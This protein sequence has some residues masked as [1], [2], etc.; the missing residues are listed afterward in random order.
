M[1]RWKLSLKILGLFVLIVPVMWIVLDPNGQRWADV[2]LL[3]LMGNPA[4]NLDFAAL[5][6]NEDLA[7][8]QKIYPKLE[9]QCEAKDGTGLN[10]VCYAHIAAINS[11]P[12]RYLSFFLQDGRL[13][14]IKLSYRAAYHEA[15]SQ[16][17][18]AVYGQPGIDRKLPPANRVATWRTGPGRV[19][20]KA[21]VSEQGD[22]QLFWLRPGYE[23]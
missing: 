21:Q 5:N 23:P 7:Q 18:T 3:R 9:F 12:A 2:N 20:M 6:G 19:V 10:Q 14:R 1:F 13:K 22:N 16:Q 11:L 8:L 15:F 4:I 17:L